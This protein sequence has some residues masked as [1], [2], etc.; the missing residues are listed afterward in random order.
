[1]FAN[2]GAPVSV[3]GM[4]MVSTFLTGLGAVPGC[5]GAARETGGAGVEDNART[6]SLEIPP[7]LP[8]ISN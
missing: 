1:M 7:E 2:G 3:L 6:D 8:T 4:G 5:G